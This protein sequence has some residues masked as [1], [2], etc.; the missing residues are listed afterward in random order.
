MTT[1]HVTR[2]RDKIHDLFHAEVSQGSYTLKAGFFVPFDLV[3]SFE[4]EYFSEELLNKHSLN[5]FIS[6]DLTLR[7]GRDTL[8]DTLGAYNLSGDT[9]THDFTR[10]Q[11]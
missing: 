6:P 1:C 4:R 7:G 5:G 3:L 9:R 10:E 11:F 8:Q 2:Y